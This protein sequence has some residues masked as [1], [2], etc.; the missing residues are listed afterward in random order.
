[1]NS[2]QPSLAVDSG[3]E[4][5]ALIETLLATEQRLEE[6]TGGEVDTVAGRDGRTFMLRRAQEQLRYSDA[7]KQAATL[8]ELQVLFDLMPAMIWFKDTEDRILRVNQRVAD[9]AGKSIEEIEG[10]P[11]SENYQEAAR[12]YQDDLEVI[13]S[14]KPKMGIVET[15]RDRNGAEV[16][17]QTD[18]VPYCDRDGKVIG[19]VVMARDLTERKKTEE[20]LRAS[21]ANMAIA[22][23]IAHFGSWE[24]D[25]TKSDH[26]GAKVLRWSDEMFRIA[27]YEP[28]AVEVSN[29][30]F[31]RLVHP[32]DREPIRQAVATA[33]RG[34]REYSIVHRLIRP[35]GEERVVRE[36]AQIFFD[37]KTGQ[38]LKII[39][40]AHDITEQR[41]AKEALRESEE[42]FAGAFEHA[43][44]GVALASPEG[45]FLKVNQVFCDLFGY[46]EAE[47]LTR[48][49]EDVTH[50]EDLA[51]TRENVRR[52]MAGE[53]R[54]TQIEKRYVHRRGHFITALLNIS[55][56]RD[57]QGQPRYFIA[58]L[59][60]ITERK[61]TELALRVSDERLRAALSASG[62]GTFRWG[63]RTNEVGWDDS[64]DALFGLPGGQTVRSLEAFIAAVH[65]EDRPG[66]LERCERCAR[67]GADFN[68]EFR[69]VWPDGSVHWLDDKGKTFFD[70]AGKPLYMTGACVDITE[71]KQTETALRA[72]EAEF[73]ALAE[74]IPHV[75][76]I[77]RPDG[78]NIYISQQ[79]M[80]YTG[81]TL[82]ESL[83]HG[84]NKPFH[85][86]DQQHAWDAWQH[87]T[88]TGCVYSMES[89]V[90][91]AD[92]V[93]R[94]WLIR[95]VPQMDAAGNMLKW[96]GTCTDIHDL[97]SAELEISR[98]NRELRESEAR[99]S[100]AFE[101]APIGM[102]LVAPE[103]RWL[104]VNRALCDLVGYSEAE[105][106]TRTFQD[107][108]HP[109]DLAADLEQV[110][111]LLAGEIPAYEM[112][113]RYFHARGHLITVLIDVSLIRDGEG[114][115]LYFIAQ[116]Q[117][118]TERKR[119]SAL[120]LESQQRLALAKESAHIGI[121]DWDVAGDN[122]VWDARMYELYG[123]RE[124]DFSGAYEAWQK[125]LHPE[126]RERGDAAIRAALD[127]IKDFHIEFRVVW[128]GG[129]VRHIEANALVQRAAD[130]SALRMIGVN[131]DITERKR[132]EAALEKTHKELVEASRKAGMAE[133]AT[134]VLHNVGNVLNSVSVASSC[135][136]DSLKRSKT[137]NL[138]KVVVLLR[139]HETDLSAF[140]T[141]HPQGKQ[142]P[143]YLAQL[144]DHL[145]GEH[146]VTL[147]ELAQ[148]QKNI[149][150]I[151]EVV[152]VQQS[153]AKGAGH[154][155]T[156][157]VT[158][159]VEDT[160]RMDSSGRDHCDIQVIREFGHPP[161][162]TAEK[163]K[164]L[165]IL[166]N[167]VR[168]AKQSCQESG[169]ADKQLIL[170]V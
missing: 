64:L 25:L 138:S 154:A 63:L 77:T 42:R 129:E 91:R 101:H 98:A 70:A 155:E 73:R 149:E 136:A 22:Q 105:L 144:A 21:G 45:R 145:A 107:I 106:L 109:E 96:F 54:S 85:P 121:W 118:I 161:A 65:P 27:G 102:S 160:L 69:V 110:R 142:I 167:L 8:N 18:K 40:T 162:I 61:R 128:P 66:V 165:Q 114:R 31:F 120:L 122:L 84:W 115:P 163:H 15:I 55:L 51:L 76:W 5:P 60:D 44:I 111:R 82:E 125:G 33:I 147:K 57:S 90:R 169:R 157:Q 43:P 156:L 9:I 123:L 62:T 124:Q 12:H 28:G 86:E 38:P 36:T 148:L 87:A 19:V 89:R 4:I 80:D 72:S 103:G 141:H 35:D 71:R 10:K 93:Y 139:E 131:W 164:V 24:L 134:G 46:A 130:G 74:A 26:A 99:F 16:W 50:P 143:D 32:E 30:L 170:R 58:Q 94:W 37:E 1:M 150:H 113:K 92:G 13:R 152:T 20:T 78:W 166:T 135:L 52:V 41:K 159:L 17:I 168:N 56:V 133:V 23:R 75:V 49:F 11:S 14:G 126:D 95:G 151:K 153:C 127:G 140:L 116:I 29:E 158:D 68:M 3:E 81:L 104:K 112:E 34:R 59:Q 97:K 100:A 2:Q 108:T 48:T 6:L 67:D 83:G 79:W 88:A 53:S 47:L 39:G 137:T 119:A 146:A 7:A 132:A 117:D